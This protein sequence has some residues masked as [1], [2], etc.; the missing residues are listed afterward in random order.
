MR[1]ALV[2]Q[3]FL[4][5]RTFFERP[6]PETFPAVTTFEND[7]HRVGMAVAGIAA[8]FTADQGSRRVLAIYSA[9]NLQTSACMSRARRATDCADVAVA[10]ARTLVSSATPLMLCTLRLISSDT[11]LCSSTADAI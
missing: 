10:A 1:P 2:V 11:A 9:L 4:S 6:A 7:A 5:A 8:P 3:R